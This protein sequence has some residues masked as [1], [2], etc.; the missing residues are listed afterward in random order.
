MIVLTAYCTQY[1]LA[2]NRNSEAG[3]KVSKMLNAI[4]SQEYLKWNFACIRGITNDTF[5]AW[6]ARVE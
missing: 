4:Q 3:I 6:D 2:L 1:L 5:V